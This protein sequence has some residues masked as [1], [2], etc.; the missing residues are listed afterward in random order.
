MEEWLKRILYVMDLAHCAECQEARWFTI[1]DFRWLLQLSGEE[2][3]QAEEAL[4]E[5]ARYGCIE[6]ETDCEGYTKY[7]H[8]TF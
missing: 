2:V 1:E 5:L 8:V 6:R 7:Q 3:A 4:E